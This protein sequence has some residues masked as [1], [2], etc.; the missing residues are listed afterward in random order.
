MSNQLKFACFILLGSSLALSVKGDPAVVDRPAITTEGAK[1]LIGK[2]EAK[3]RSLSRTDRVDCAR[4]ALRSITAGAVEMQGGIPIKRRAEIVGAI[5]VSGADA[6]TDVA[7]AEAAL[8][9]LAE[10]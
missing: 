8:A 5:G 10:Y 1:A 6:S 2:A 7:I 4:R 9:D 3:A